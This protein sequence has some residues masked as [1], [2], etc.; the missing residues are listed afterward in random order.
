MKLKNCLLAMCFMF[1]PF[2]A[3]ASFFN[4]FESMSSEQ[5]ER[6]LLAALGHKGQVELL[7]AQCAAAVQELEQRQGAAAQAVPASSAMPS[8]RTSNLQVYQQ[9]QR[10]KDQSKNIQFMKKI[11][12]VLPNE[13]SSKASVDELMAFLPGFQNELEE[14][15]R[16]L[17][18]LSLRP[19]DLAREQ[20]QLAERANNLKLLNNQLMDRKRLAK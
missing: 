9:R 11:Q 10:S 3:F 14:D 15:Q 13:H 6:V 2:T 18:G 19:D 20:Q 16:V 12:N 1:I 5:R 17:S 8:P 4:P 7:K